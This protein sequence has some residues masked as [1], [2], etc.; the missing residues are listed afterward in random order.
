L[1]LVP[2]VRYFEN[3]PKVS[4]GLLDPYRAYTKVACQ[5][6]TSFMRG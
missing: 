4:I 5:K 2:S 6:D 3:F 1:H